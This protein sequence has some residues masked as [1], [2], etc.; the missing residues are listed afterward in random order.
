MG[1]LSLLAAMLTLLR[2]SHASSLY[3]TQ[4]NTDVIKEDVH[5]PFRPYPYYTQVNNF[6]DAE[7]Q[8]TT[9]M[10]DER[11]CY[12]TE[13]RFG[14]CMS[15]RSCYPTSILNN[16]ETWSVIIR[17]PCSYLV[18]GGKQIHGICCPKLVQITPLVIEPYPAIL[19][20]LVTVN[21]APILSAETTISPSSPLMEKQ[22]AVE[23]KQISCGAGPAKIL[24][25]EEDRIVG[26][27]DAVKNSWPYAVLLKFSGRFF[28]GGTLISPNRV[29][30]AAHCVDFFWPWDY[31][32]VTVELGVHVLRP[33]SDALVS[34]RVF[35]VLSHRN[36]NPYFLVNDIAILVLKFP[37]NYVTEISP[38]CLP[39][40][41]TTD[42]YV[43]EEAAIIGWGS[44]QDQYGP[45]PE[46]LQ[47]ATIKI[48]SNA[49]CQASYNSMG[50]TIEDSMICATAPGTS[51]CYGDSGG[52]LLIKSS[53]TARWTEV[54]IVSFG[55]VACASPDYPAV[56]TRVT[57]FS[58]W[59]SQR[60]M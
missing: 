18:E 20:P 6:D 37:V 14:S 47:Q 7:M 30:T 23:S 34:R 4:Q 58:S 39:A 48:V 53:S 57:S 8:N 49:E 44:L 52:A 9:I 15:L 2:F 19:N 13:G 28:C 12:T 26:G 27:T 22:M 31:L 33:T 41:G 11:S 25:F 40:P 17:I 1:A 32:R 38:V 16:L 43:G 55:S 21:V 3:Q 59:I 60:I 54:G 36:F 24:S 51:S 10:M 29:L 35:K 46:V 45:L 50:V 42:T 5:L 56:Y